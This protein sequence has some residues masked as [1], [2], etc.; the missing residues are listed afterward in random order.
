MKAWARLSFGFIGGHRGQPSGRRGPNQTSYSS[1]YLRA[2]EQNND[3]LMG[4][5]SDRKTW[6][7]SEIVNA[8]SLLVSHSRPRVTRFLA[9]RLG[10]DAETA[11]VY[12]QGRFHK[13]VRSS[14]HALEG[15]P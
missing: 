4:R 6:L 9:S 2:D 10:D 7:S 3:G 15:R 8:Y 12:G 13:Q 11:Y 14:G 5:L 1:G